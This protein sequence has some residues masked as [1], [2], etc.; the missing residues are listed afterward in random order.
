MYS[1]M[2]S[3]IK[4]QVME[5]W[6][7]CGEFKD[8]F[9]VTVGGNSEEDCMQK[10]IDLSDKHRNLIWYS[11]YS[12]EDYEAGEFIGRDNFIYD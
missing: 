1:N 11:G 2:I 8:G 7:V 3:D 4:T 5:P 9:S 12:D 10:L 6:R